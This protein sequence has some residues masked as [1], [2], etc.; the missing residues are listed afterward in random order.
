MKDP[1][2]KAIEL[3]EKSKPMAHANLFSF[4]EESFNNNCRKIALMVCD[5]MIK[6]LEKLSIQESGTSLID[7]GQIYW[8]EVKNELEKM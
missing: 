1:K 3:F 8:K 5:E 4:R 7:F 2:Q 6:H